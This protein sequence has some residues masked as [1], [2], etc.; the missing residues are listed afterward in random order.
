MVPF[1]LKTKNFKLLGKLET[2][3]PQLMGK[4]WE[5]RLKIF[6]PRKSWISP[7]KSPLRTLTSVSRRCAS[8]K[9]T[10]VHHGPYHPI[11]KSPKVVIFLSW[12]KGHICPLRFF[13]CLV[14][15]EIEVGKKSSVGFTAC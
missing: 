7:Q 5:K 11:C 12:P 3:T 15:V 6:L 9:K 1:W 8:G 2:G 10:M 14:E 13:A 4:T